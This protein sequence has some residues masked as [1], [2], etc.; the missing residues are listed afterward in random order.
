MSHATALALLDVHMAIND[1]AW[2]AYMATV[3]G[4]HDAAIAIKRV[5]ESQAPIDRMY[6]TVCATN[7]LPRF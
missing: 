6:D 7:F 2:E 3:P 4:S 5:A 1:A